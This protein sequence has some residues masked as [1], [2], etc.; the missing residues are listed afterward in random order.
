MASVRRMF[1]RGQYQSDPRLLA[2][3]KTNPNLQLPVHLTERHSHN[4]DSG[5]SGVELVEAST[6]R[7]SAHGGGAAGRRG[8]DIRLRSSKEAAFRRA[9]G[10]VAAAQ[11]FARRGGAEEE[12]RRG[13]SAPDA[14]QSSKSYR[15]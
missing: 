3:A 7:F 14:M 4:V 9:V 11:R 1:K 2:R 10:F 12:R 15:G 6:L 5:Q 13:P 8:D